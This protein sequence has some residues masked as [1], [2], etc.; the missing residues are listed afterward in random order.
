MKG[1]YSRSFLK[2]PRNPVLQWS[3]GKLIS[4][5]SSIFVCFRPKRTEYKRIQVSQEKRQEKHLSTCAGSRHTL[6]VNQRAGFHS[7]R[8]Y[9]CGGLFKTA[10]QRSSYKCVIKT[11]SWFRKYLASRRNSGKEENRKTGKNHRKSN[12]FEHKHDWSTIISVFKRE[13]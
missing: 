5:K 10:N 3:Q 11:L 13:M 6:S 8:R 9:F 1:L 4:C 7:A 2:I 12:T